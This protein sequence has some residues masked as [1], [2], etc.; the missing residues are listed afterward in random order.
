MRAPLVVFGLVYAFTCLVGALLMM[1]GYHDFVG[2]FEYFSGTPVPHLTTA[3][4]LLD[5]LLLLVAPLYLWIG[6]ELAL[7]LAPDRFPGIRAA[8]TK[9]A[10]ARLETPTWLPIVVFLVSIAGGFAAIIRSGSAGNISS[11]FDYQTW[12]HARAQT[13]TGMSFAEFV[14]IYLFVPLAAAWIVVTLRGPGFLRLVVRWLPLGLTLL[15]DVLLFQKKTAVV[16]LLIVVFAWSLAYA[17]TSPRRLLMG[18]LATGLA[19]LV[20]YFG[21]VVVPIYS[22]ASGTVCGV[23]GISCNGVVT[24]VPAVVLYAVLAPL[25]RTSAPALWYPVIFPREHAFYR[26]DVGL[27]VLG[28]GT[29]PDDNLVVWHDL[30]PHS[31]GTTVV[32]FQFTLFS[33]GGVIVALVGSL[34]AGFVLALGWR[35]T[36]SEAVPR[37]WSS[38]VGAMVLLLAVYIAIDSARNSTIVSYGVA[39]GLLF[40]IVAGVVVHLGRTGG[41][42]RSIGRRVRSRPRR[43]RVLGT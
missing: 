17:R 34:L 11:W 39:W 41:W 4:I 30:N 1:S 32:P 19:V 13:F 29:F 33:Q 2:L 37:A 18:G 9:L 14:N 20:V 5:L 38:L 7:R 26:P 6:Y 23:Q 3:Q 16:S 40:I 43:T 12:V 27:D 15:L 22:K 31:P 42:R 8:R 28:I 21:A 36:L 24:K 10:A 25:T 35:F